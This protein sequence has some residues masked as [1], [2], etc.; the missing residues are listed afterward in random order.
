MT[1]GRLALVFAVLSLLG[2]GG[3]S[4]IIPQMHADVVDRF[5]WITSAEFARFYALGRLAPGPTTTMAALVGWRVAGFA[6]AALAALAI[7]V[8][9]ALVVHALGRVWQRLHGHPWRDRFARGIAPVVLGLVW[10]SVATIGRGALDGAPTVA[11][12]LAAT[13]LMLR[14]QINQ[15]LLILGAGVLGALI[16]R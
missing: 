16:L 14:T 8:P 3:G 2:F 12:A 11:I 7:F 10:A 13:I 4:A 9:A 1:L 15:S 5:R 6:G